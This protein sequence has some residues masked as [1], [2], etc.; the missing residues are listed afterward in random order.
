MFPGR[1]CKS[2]FLF[3]WENAT[4]RILL[5][6]YCHASQVFARLESP[7]QKYQN[8]DIFHIS[9]YVHEYKFVLLVS[10]DEPISTMNGDDKSFS[11]VLLVC[12]LTIS[13]R[14]QLNAR[15]QIS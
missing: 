2:L 3:T 6:G 15:L 12:V 10:A 1:T 13:S 7:G 8:I 9:K 14:S 5:D 4:I 11:V